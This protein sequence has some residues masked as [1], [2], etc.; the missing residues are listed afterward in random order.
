VL[1]AVGMAGS[2]PYTATKHGV[3][4]LTQAAALEGGAAGIRVNAV[5]PGFIH[6]PMLKD[7]E[8]DAATH[9]RLIAAHPLGRLGRPEEVAEMVAWLCSDRASFVTGAYCPVDGG[10]L[11]R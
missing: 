2:A 9:A 3:V 11:A 5:G 7:L 10:F 4:G 6:T 1:G 8:S